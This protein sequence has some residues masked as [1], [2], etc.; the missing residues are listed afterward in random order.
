MGASGEKGHYRMEWVW[1]TEDL[2]GIE[3][4]LGEV[5]GV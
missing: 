2:I 3:V 5:L 1:D 4:G